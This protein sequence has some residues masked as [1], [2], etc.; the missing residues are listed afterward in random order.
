M[1]RLRGKKYSYLQICRSIT[2]AHLQMVARDTMV[3]FEHKFLNKHGLQSGCV[4]LIH[5]EALPVSYLAL[6]RHINEYT[7][8]RVFRMILLACD[9][10]NMTGEQCQ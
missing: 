8:S 3:N 5:V 10:S 1:S 4:Y 7:M 2:T 9:Y 6:T